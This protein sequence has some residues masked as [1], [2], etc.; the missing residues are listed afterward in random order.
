MSSGAA[1]YGIALDHGIDSG[2]GWFLTQW[3]AKAGELFADEENGRAGRA[4]EVLFDSQAGVDQLG[5]LQ[6]LVA[7]G[8]AVDVGPN[9]GGQDTL[10]KMADPN[11]PAAMSINSS[12]ALGSVLS[13]LE[14]GGVE[15]FTTEDLGV[16]PM[17]GPG[18][19][20]GILVG[21]AA[22]WLVEGKDDAETAAAWDYIT[23][24]TSPEAQ[25]EWAAATG[26]V[27]VRTESL[28]TE[29]LASKYQQDPASPSPTSSSP[30]AS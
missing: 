24:L 27:P 12:A 29:P 28:E 8:L 21:G 22:L 20:E 11:A 10:L 7:D 14:S 15:G 26:Y 2:G 9:A 1:T 6:S 25:A 30:P 5:F 17:P 13:V 16:A 18:G 23:Y 4:D 3:F 19:S